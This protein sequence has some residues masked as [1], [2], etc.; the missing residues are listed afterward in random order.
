MPVPSSGNILSCSHEG[1]YDNIRVYPDTLLQRDDPVDGITSRYVLEPNVHGESI[2]SNLKGLYSISPWF[3]PDNR[4]GLF[5][6]LCRIMCLGRPSEFPRSLINFP[7][8][9]LPPTIK[10][11]KMSSIWK[12]FEEAMIEIQ[13]PTSMF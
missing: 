9:E 7:Y 5:N 6:Q 13:I 8:T 2:W 10:Q 4:I 12:C 1:M 11:C 3:F